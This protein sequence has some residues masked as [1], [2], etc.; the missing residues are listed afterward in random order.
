LPALKKNKKVPDENVTNLRLKVNNKS[1]FMPEQT[2]PG[3][4][5]R[6]LKSH[7]GA[8]PPLKR[9]IKLACFL[10]IGSD[11]EIENSPLERG[12]PP[13][14][15]R[16]GPGCVVQRYALGP[17]EMLKLVTFVPDEI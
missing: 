6:S 11:L 17:D 5:S 12:G 9:G 2:H 14:G 10:E 16:E 15:Y 13:C 4:S 1:I 8:A 7:L 3:C